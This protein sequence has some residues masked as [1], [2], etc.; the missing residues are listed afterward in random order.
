MRKKKRVN[1]GRPFELEVRIIEA[2]TRDVVAK[3]AVAVLGLSLLGAAILDFGSE[4]CGNVHAVWSAAGPLIG[5][6]FVYFFAPR[7]SK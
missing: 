5:G 2:R 3:A 6:I 1:V 7:D 4:S